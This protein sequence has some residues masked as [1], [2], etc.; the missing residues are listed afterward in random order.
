MPLLDPRK[1]VSDGTRKAHARLI[2]DKLFKSNVYHYDIESLAKLFNQVSQYTEAETL[3]PNKLQWGYSIT[4]IQS[5]YYVLHQLGL[6]GTDMQ[7]QV[8]QGIVAALLYIFGDKILNKPLIDK[9]V[10]HGND[11]TR[12]DWID[13]CVLRRTN[14]ELFGAEHYC[15]NEQQYETPSQLSQVFMC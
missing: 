13:K 6:R 3:N 5:A 7:Q 12:N 15:D 11:H 1:K 9:L 10:P 2:R 14:L 8:K 4:A